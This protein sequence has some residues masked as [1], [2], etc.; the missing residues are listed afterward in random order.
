MKKKGFTLIELLAVIIILAI[1]ALIAT[2]MVLNV[3]EDTKKS[4]AKTEAIHIV[5]GVNKYC[6]MVDLKNQLG[7]TTVEACGASLDKAAIANK[8][9]EGGNYD[10]ATI[11]Y[12][13]GKVTSATV[14]SN[15]YT[16]TYTNGTY[17]VSK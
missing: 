1:I 12:A 6:A 3:I 9:I 17:S 10:S 5:D 11:S 14:V 16:V 8:M 2:P 13:N 4:A 15:G 7:E